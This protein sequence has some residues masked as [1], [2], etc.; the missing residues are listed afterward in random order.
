MLF[1][2]LFKLIGWILFPLGIAIVF[3]AWL[4]YF[5]FGVDA[6][7]KWLIFLNGNIVWA[8]VLTLVG[9]FL[10]ALGVVMSKAQ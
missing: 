9:G 4:G 2:A 7:V 6:G 3:G 10:T 8:I 1:T 5:S